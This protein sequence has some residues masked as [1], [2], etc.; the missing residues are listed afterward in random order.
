MNKNISIRFY[1]RN[2]RHQW[3]YSE[4]MQKGMQL[5][6]FTNVKVLQHNQYDP[7]NSPE[8]AIFWAHKR[9]DI[10][11][12]QRKQRK[13]Y[14]VME[15]A[16]I[17]DR[18]HWVSFGYNGLNGR[19]NFCNQDVKSE[20]RFITHF[21]EYLKPWNYNS[22]QTGEYALVIGQ[23]ATDASVRDININQWYIK[24]IRHLNKLNIPVV[25]RKHPLCKHTSIDHH[26]LKFVYDDGTK[27]LENVLKKAKFT[28]T[29]SSNSGVISFLEGIPTIAYDQGSMIYNHVKHDLEDL[30][31]YPD[32]TQ[33]C[34]EISYCQ[35]LPEELADGTA[36]KHLM[37]GIE[38]VKT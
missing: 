15:R 24:V 27:P 34:K 36:W 23:V 7:F 17:G 13:Q 11:S 20:K 9:N 25:F 5:H 19:A 1:P 16:Y 26:N 4:A 29:Y 35:W 2:A 30:Y 22:E 3:K 18:H 31:Y 32:R 6:G 33:W 8:L 10:I 14:M 21:S 37:K 12:N 38:H 28:V